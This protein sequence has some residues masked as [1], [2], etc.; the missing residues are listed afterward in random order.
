MPPEDRWLAGWL[1]AA[2]LLAVG[3]IVVNAW[4]F[5]YTGISYFPREFWWLAFAAFDLA[6]F[7]HRVRERAP[8]ASFV[9]TNLAFYAL[10]AAVMGVL[11]TGIQ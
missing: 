10:T 2:L 4:C 3:L 9:S 11:A 7:G 5:H 1:L 6:I 8:Y